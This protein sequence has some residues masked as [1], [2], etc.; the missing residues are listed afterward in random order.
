MNKQAVLDQ[1]IA[2]IHAQGGPGQQHNGCFYR[3]SDGR[4]SAI[5]CLIPD[6]IYSGS[7]EDYDPS[8]LP[9]HV[10]DTLDADSDC[11]IEFLVLLESAHD[12]AAKTS[13]DE[14]KDFWS[15]WT[16]ALQTVT[17]DYAVSLSLVVTLGPPKAQRTEIRPPIKLARL[18]K[19]PLI[20]E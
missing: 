6:E 13:W 7:L 19:P 15:E 1:V 4:K 8:Q 2:F 17:S 9:R 11:E 18:G 10:L 14:G 3:T 12:L 5:G 20:L 16:T